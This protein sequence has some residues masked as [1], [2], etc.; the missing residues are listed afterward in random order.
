MAQPERIPVPGD[1]LI[2]SA[3]IEA[4]YFNRTV[5]LILDHEDS[6]TLGVV[7]NRFAEPQ[8]HAVLPQW[9]DQVSQPRVLFSGGPVSP[10]GAICLA[11]VAGDEEPPGF[12]PVFDQVGLLHLDTPIEIVEGAYADLRI[13][14]GYA[15]WSAGQLAGELAQDMW[16]VV[17]SEYGDVFG[18]DPETLWRRCLR[19]QPGDLAWFSTWCDDPEQN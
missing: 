17:S 3:G 19:R 18:P 10:N 8:L 7:L 12:R 11:A 13:F 14:A 6:G 4:G 15:G 1:L 9:V 5:V 2:A 16:W